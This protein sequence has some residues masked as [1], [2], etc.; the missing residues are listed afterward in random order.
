MKNLK[1]MLAMV[2]VVMAMSFVLCGCSGQK[3]ILMEDVIQAS[4][5]KAEPADW[6]SDEAIS[7][8]TNTQL[9]AKLQRTYMQL[10]ADKNRKVMMKDPE[11]WIAEIQ[12]NETGIYVGNEKNNVKFF[13]SNSGNVVQ[14][15][16]VCRTLYRM[17]YFDGESRKAYDSIELDYSEKDSNLVKIAAT[18]EF[19]VMYNAQDNTYQC[20]KFGKVIGTS[21]VTNLDATISPDGTPKNY[22]ENKGF[23]HQKEVYVPVVEKTENNTTFYVVKESE[24]DAAN[25]TFSYID[26]KIGNLEAK[27]CEIV[28]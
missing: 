6:Y 25:K 15:S 22:G 16:K 10:I 17:E 5:L 9:P 20:M 12:S 7:E 21:A 27:A 1:S 23:V 26:M 4:T 11:G 19:S 28:K 8:L 14:V 18:D 3:T 24:F 2:V 13:Q